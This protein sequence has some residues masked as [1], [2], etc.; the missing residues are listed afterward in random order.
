MRAI[1]VVVNFLG[2]YHFLTGPSYSNVGYGRWFAA[3]II[4]NVLDLEARR[5]RRPRKIDLRQNATRVERYRKAY[6]KYDWTGML[7][8]S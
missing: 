7:R 4:G 8:S 3:E 5:W 6:A 1:A 2:E